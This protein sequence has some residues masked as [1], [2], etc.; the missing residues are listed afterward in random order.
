MASTATAE[1]TIQERGILATGASASYLDCF[2]NADR[3]FVSML[4]QPMPRRRRYDSRGKTYT[5]DW[6]DYGQ[7]LP[8]WFDPLMQG[9]VDL[10][11]LP[12]NWDSYGAG[13]VDA[14]VVHAAINFI[15]GF[16]R[17]SSPAPRVVPLSSG[18]LQLEWRRKGVDLEIVFDRDAKPFFYWRDR[19]SGEESEH[20]LRESSALLRIRIENLE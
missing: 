2:S 17:P 19:V 11:T 9:F 20:A 15:N 4:P 12:P 13:A 16:L 7:P 1:L 8:V 5:I 14:R 18:G 6:Q 10:L 3:V